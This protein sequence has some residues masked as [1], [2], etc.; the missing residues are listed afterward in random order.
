LKNGKLASYFFWFYGKVV[1]PSSVTS[2][3]VRPPRSA[4][5]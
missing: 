3:F 2:H 1:V 4:L 5:F